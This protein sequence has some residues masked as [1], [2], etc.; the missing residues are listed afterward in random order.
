MRK[1]LLLTILVLIGKYQLYSQIT[2]RDVALKVVP[3]PEP[4]DSSDFDGSKDMKIYIN[5]DIYILPEWNDPDFNRSIINGYKYFLTEPIADAYNKDRSKVYKLDD[6]STGCDLVTKYDALANKYFKILDAFIVQRDYY[7]F[8]LLNKENHDTLY[9]LIARDISFIR[10]QWR[11][12]FIFVGHF[13]KLKKNNVGREFI[14]KNISNDI[15]IGGDVFDDNDNYY[16]TT[17]IN[18]GLPIKF[19][20]GSKW[21]C[22]DLTLVKG[23]LRFIFKNEKNEDI[24][25]KTKKMD[26]YFDRD[27]FISVKEAKAEEER[28]R[29]TETAREALRMKKEKEKQEKKKKILEE[30][31][32]KF[33]EEYAKLI[34]G[35]KVVIGMTKEM[36]L[37]AWGTPYDINK[38][39]TSSMI[40]EIWS[41]SMKT[42]L[43]FEDNKLTLIKN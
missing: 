15:E 39:T 28:I 8:K 12:P 29:L 35:Q 34:I 40:Q 25:V 2:T 18:T 13:E 38:I 21:N 24:Q 31:T 9:H 23:E 14:M 20:A 17:D 36:C 30:Y 33:G 1:I 27:D 26:F 19:Y 41:Y 37:L 11:V 42:F 10:R 3:K 7:Y 5:Q 4:Y 16:E 32:N 43:Y 6:H 22:V